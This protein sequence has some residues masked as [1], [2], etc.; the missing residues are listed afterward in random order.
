[1]SYKLIVTPKFERQLK[2]LKKKY[3]KIKDDFTLCI[4]KLEKDIFSGTPLGKRLYK[5]RLKSSDKSGGK[6]GGFRVIYYL[7][8][9]DEELY[10]LTIYSKSEI[11][12]I[13]IDKILK[14]LEDLHL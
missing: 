14:L 11:E 13:S 2:Q 8:T 3:K 1:M 9:Q 4:E 7:V 10:F 12:N 6:S 5:L